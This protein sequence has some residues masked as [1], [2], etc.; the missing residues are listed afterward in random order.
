[1]LVIPDGTA[2]NIPLNTPIS[3]LNE[4]VK[5]NLE[6]PVC[7]IKW[8][9]LKL[10]KF[11]KIT[12]H[13]VTV[14]H[15]GLPIYRLYN[16]CVNQSE[17]NDVDVNTEKGEI[18]FNK[19]SVSLKFLKSLKTDHNVDEIVIAP[20]LGNFEVVKNKSLQQKY[21]NLPLYQHESTIL[22]FVKNQSRTPDT[23]IKIYYNN[24]NILTNIHHDYDKNITNNPQNYITSPGHP[25]ID[26]SIIGKQKI[27]DDRNIL[28]KVTQF[29]AQHID[30]NITFDSKLETENTSN[31]LKLEF[32]NLYNKK[33]KCY[34]ATK[35]QFLDINDIA[36]ENDELIFYENKRSTMKEYILTL[37]DYGINNNSILNVTPIKT[38]GQLFI[39]GLTG[40]TKTYD[41][42]HNMT[43]KRLKYLIELD[44]GIPWKDQRLVYGGKQL[45]DEKLLSQHGTMSPG[46]ESTI[47]LVL[48]LLGGPSRSTIDYLAKKHNNKG[49]TQLILLD[50][51]NNIND[52]NTYTYET[53]KINI[54]NSVQYNDVMPNVDIDPKKYEA[55]KLPFPSTIF[56]EKKIKYE[57]RKKMGCLKCST[58]KFCSK[59]ILDK[60]I[61]GIIYSILFN[62]YS[63]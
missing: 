36:D 62:L 2:F 39:K 9:N 34:N 38:C 33:F 20:N 3:K 41:Y 1:M 23:A 43:T 25:W 49:I 57:I 27:V 18:N 44:T 37:E 31:E 22:Q 17:Y 21:I 63:V 51:K 7:D 4:Y 12:K 56:N 54:M 6:I 35:E 47:H 42:E 48:R 11:Y 53:F 10:V 8:H 14:Q 15:S 40:A 50:K 46:K 5:H 32:Y 24:K 45:E 59:N 52:W 13:T 61:L 28:S 55:L 29:Y 16:E 26:G 19:S 30:T 58:F 60:D